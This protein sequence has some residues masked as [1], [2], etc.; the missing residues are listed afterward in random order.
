[1]LKGK[2]FKESRLKFLDCCLMLLL[3]ACER[4]KRGLKH[5]SFAEMSFAEMS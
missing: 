5:F 2:E 1:M 4:E 3:L